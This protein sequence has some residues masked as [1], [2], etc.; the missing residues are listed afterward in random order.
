MDL[1]GKLVN[2]Q[3]GEQI[4]YFHNVE[5]IK[6]WFWVGNKYNY[7]DRRHIAYLFNFCPT[8]NSLHMFPIT[9]CEELVK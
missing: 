1:Y 3:T 5:E 7:P 8:V 6:K 9:N 2:V 4:K